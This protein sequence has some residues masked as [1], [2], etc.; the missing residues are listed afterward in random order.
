ML[1]HAWDTSTAAGG[2]FVTMIA[3]GSLILKVSN[4][5]SCFSD[6]KQWLC[7]TY[8]YLY[9]LNLLVPTYTKIPGGLPYSLSL[10]SRF[11]NHRL[12]HHFQYKTVTFS[13]TLHIKDSRLSSISVGSEVLLLLWSWPPVGSTLEQTIATFYRRQKTLNSCYSRA[14]VI[15]AQCNC[16]LM[17]LV[18][19]YL[20]LRGRVPE[21]QYV[22]IYFCTGIL[23]S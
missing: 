21:C 8:V 22:L 14:S 6:T 7:L 2:L 3:S 4:A 10:H 11:E 9:I 18:A 23:V 12:C 1:L 16:V 20:L 13:P 19:F 17:D 15:Y 5:V